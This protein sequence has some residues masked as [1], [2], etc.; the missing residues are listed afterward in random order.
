MEEYK[1]FQWNE[2]S[3]YQFPILSQKDRLEREYREQEYEFLYR[4]FINIY[5]NNDCERFIW[6]EW[7]NGE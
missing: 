4:R 1:E 6:G 3:Y 5:D 7:Q 2:M